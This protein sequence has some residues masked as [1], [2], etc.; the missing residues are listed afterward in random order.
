[1]TFRVATRTKRTVEIIWVPRPASK[2]DIDSP[3]LPV[4]ARMGAKLH[5][6]GRKAASP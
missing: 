6:K 4:L 2:P 3:L 5:Q 1:M